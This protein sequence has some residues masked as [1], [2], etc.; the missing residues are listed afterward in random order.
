[1]QQHIDYEEEQEAGVQS[2]PEPAE[3]IQEN[4]VGYKGHLNAPNS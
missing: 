2:P 4:V 1:M 3:N